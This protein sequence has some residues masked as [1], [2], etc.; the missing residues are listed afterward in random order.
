MSSRA[1]PLFEPFISRTTPQPVDGEIT[2]VE[3]EVT[4]VTVVRHDRSAG[5]VG[6]V[7]SHGV[8]GL[9]RHRRDACVQ[10]V[11]PSRR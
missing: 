6:L 9:V 8:T 11:D 3:V 2:I 4:R 5:D 10:L 1:C 7:P